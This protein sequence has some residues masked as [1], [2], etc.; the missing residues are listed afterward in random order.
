MHRKKERERERESQSEKSL[1][2]GTLMEKW[3]G[4]RRVKFRHFRLCISKDNTKFILGSVI[5]RTK[6]RPIYI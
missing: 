1:K 3:F 6:C 5:F 2:F 4:I